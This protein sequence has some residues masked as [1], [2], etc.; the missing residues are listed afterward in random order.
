MGI[1]KLH[2]SQCYH[3][4]AENISELRD[5]SSSHLTVKAADLDKGR[6]LISKH[7]IITGEHEIC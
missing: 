1:E 7:R 2:H 4:V 6:Y 3:S 5:G